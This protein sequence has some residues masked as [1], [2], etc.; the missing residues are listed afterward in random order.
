MPLSNNNSGGGYFKNLK[1]LA[2]FL[3]ITVGVVTLKNLQAITL[4]IFNLHKFKYKRKT[5]RNDSTKAE[6]L[7]WDKL[8]RSQFLNLK[9]RRQ[10]GI[11]RYVVDFYCPELKLVIELDGASHNN[12]D[13][14]EYDLIR[15][16]FFNEQ[17]I[18]VLRFTNENVYSNLSSVLNTMAR[19]V[20]IINHSKL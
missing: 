1:A 19:E 5:L 12:S 20:E 16:E 2:P 7:L 6:I 4:K 10:Q 11:G 14:I 18:K 17:D 9:F 13:S 8:K 15:S 3:I